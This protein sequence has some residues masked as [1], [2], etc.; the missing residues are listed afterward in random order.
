MVITKTV[1]I[2]TY[3]VKNS[4]NKIPI[5]QGFVGPYQVTARRHTGCSSVVVKKQF[6]KENQYTG[7]VDIC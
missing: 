4:D 7:T 1:I 2:F 3:L 5:T 6:V